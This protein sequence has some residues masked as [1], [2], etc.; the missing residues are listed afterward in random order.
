MNFPIAGE[1]NVLVVNIIDRGRERRVVG[2]ISETSRSSVQTRLATRSPSPPARNGERGLVQKIA[3]GAIS[4]RRCRSGAERGGLGTRFVLSSLP[5]NKTQE[6]Q[7]CAVRT[8]WGGGVLS[9]GTPVPVEEGGQ[10]ASLHPA[11]VH[12][13]YMSRFG[14]LIRQLSAYKTVL[15]RGGRKAG[16]SAS[17]HTGSS[18]NTSTLALKARG[19]S[20]STPRYFRTSLWEPHTLGVHALRWLQAL[21]RCKKIAHKGQKCLST[22]D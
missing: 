2:T 1:I 11:D 3:P 5:S 4:Q 22:L 13:P 15:G 12:H 20:R 16:V 14:L 19:V 17:E 21:E 18:R 7:K 6:R 9:V 10:V 8:C